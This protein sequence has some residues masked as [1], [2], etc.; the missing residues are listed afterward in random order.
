MRTLVFDIETVP[1]AD[2]GRRMFELGDDLPDEDVVRALE[3]LQF[4]KNGRTFLPHY[5]HR[6]VA[7]SLLLSSPGDEPQL[8]SL[9]GG[10]AEMLERFFHGIDKYTPQLVSWNGAHFDMPV[11]HYRSLLH[12]VAAPRY[13]DTGDDD[14]EFRYNNYLNRYHARHLDL[15]DVLSL[16]DFHAVAPLDGVAK[17]IGAPG[18][19][20]V[21]GAQVWDLFR[22]GELGRIRNYCETD[23]LNT[24][25]V[26]LRFQQ[27]RGHLSAA[28]WA[29]RV[30]RL[31]TALEAS[32]KEHLC[33]FAASMKQ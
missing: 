25:L 1:D 2:A 32:G 27:I 18:K 28:T 26:Y 10:E 6:V 33:E 30:A 29:Q 20:G 8:W 11:I 15:M 4:Q 23:V 12:G 14:R 21:E 24:Y 19:P 5:L 31:R 3:Q 17:L 22:A 16:Y 13:W 9:D 7:I